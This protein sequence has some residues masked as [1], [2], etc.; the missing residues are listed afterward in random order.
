MVLLTTATYPRPVEHRPLVCLGEALVDL[1]CPDPV[2]DLADANTFEPHFGGALAN[3]AVA[4]ARAGAPVSL[5]GG[6]GADERGR[7]L[8]NRLVEE[9]VGLEHHSLLEDAETP[10]AHVTLDD[11]REP[12]FRIEGDGI[13]EGIASL[14]GHENE[15]VASAGAIAFGSN[16]LPG[17]R[18][19]EVTEA[20]VDA[21]AETGIPV[22][23]DPN[24]R[25]GRWDDLERAREMCLGLIARATVLKC[26]VTEGRWLAGSEGEAGML[27]D[28]LVDLGPQ[29]VVITAGTDPLVAR[30]ICEIEVKP[31]SV[32]TVSP[33]GAGD[34]F[35]GTM[36][37]GVLMDGW[38]PESVAATLERAAAAGA[39]ACT[40]LGAF[41]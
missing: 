12:T 2:S 30:G 6:C 24:L 3:V 31:P 35:M 19:S 36:A 25:R 11:A 21:A 27:A 15:L 40:H 41:D 28:A 34:V 14:R 5:A 17:E 37:A 7:F 39:D 23:F 18:S 20:V 29:L 38:E 4:A 33:L 1:I 16:T 32:E 26:N 9:G 22:M 8:R 10:L 13:E